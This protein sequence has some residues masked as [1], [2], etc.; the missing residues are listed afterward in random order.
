MR[1]ITYFMKT[2]DDC[3]KKRPY[4]EDEENEYFN[5]QHGYLDL[6]GCNIDRVKMQCKR[7]S[8][9]F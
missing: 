9:E 7:L 1:G 8:S 6:S 5:Q 3:L 2:E 4:M